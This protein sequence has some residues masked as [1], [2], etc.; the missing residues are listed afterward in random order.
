[1]YIKNYCPNCGCDT[2]H[3]IW[4]EDWLGQTGLSR[5][6]MGIC[7]ATVSMWDSETYC[8]CCSCGKTKRI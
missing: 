6:I 8:K 3:K 4:K 5:L 1:M 7:T 2:T